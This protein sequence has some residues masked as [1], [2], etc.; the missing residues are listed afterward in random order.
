M[1]S[2]SLAKISWARRQIWTSS[3]PGCSTTKVIALRVLSELRCTSS[4][5]GSA[6]P[7]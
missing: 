4:N 6:H 1:P 2:W 5:A 3:R 7:S